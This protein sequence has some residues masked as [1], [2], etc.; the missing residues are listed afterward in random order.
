MGCLMAWLGRAGVQTD[1]EAEA[2]AR[3]LRDL[4]GARA[5]AWCAA[6]LA[7]LPPN[8]ARRKSI[9]KIAAALR[10]AP[11]GAPSASTVAKRPEHR[12]QPRAAGRS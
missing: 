8:D 1:A 4:Y 9:R 10:A 11:N 2:D 6:S 5:E 12:F 3:H 7:A